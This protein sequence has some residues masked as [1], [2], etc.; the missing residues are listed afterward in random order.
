MSFQDYINN[1][2]NKSTTNNASNNQP[3]MDN[4]QQSYQKFMGLSQEE[5][6][7]ELFRTAEASREKGELNDSML[8]NFYNQALMMLT[9]EQRERMKEIIIELK[10][11]K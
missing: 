1:K 9:P 4:L 5:L 8:D 10:K 6:M 2:N 7:Q 3:N 11:Q